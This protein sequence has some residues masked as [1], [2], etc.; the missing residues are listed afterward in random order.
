[1]FLLAGIP[2]RLQNYADTASQSMTP[3]SRPENLDNMDEAQRDFHEYRYRC[4]L[5][6]YHYVISTMEHNRLHYEAF[7]DP[8]FALRGRLFLHAGAPWEGETFDLKVALIQAMNNWEKLAGGGVPCPFEFNAEDLDQTAALG[9][10]LSIAARGFEI[11]QSMGRAG[12]EGWVPTEDYEGAMAFFKECKKESL[13]DV[14]SAEER[15]EIEGHWPWDDM[16]E[17]MYM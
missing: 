14:K 2:Q 8:F 17:E 10:E 6:H 5:V 1:M 7:T 13:A 3:P 4:R 16:D 11:I 12:E 15:E 9:K